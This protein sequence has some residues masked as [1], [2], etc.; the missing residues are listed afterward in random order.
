[1][2]TV[3]VWFVAD[4]K[5]LEGDTLLLYGWRVKS[6]QNGLCF[7]V[8]CRDDARSKRYTPDYAST[9]RDNNISGATSKE[10]DIGPAGKL[11]TA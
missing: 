7:Q 6:L 10:R 9:C 3:E 5:K 2:V 11:E 8:C 4:I 1:M